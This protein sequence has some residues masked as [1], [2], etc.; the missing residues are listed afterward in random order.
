DPMVIAR[1]ALLIVVVNGCERRLFAA[2]AAAA[3]FAFS[4]TV[5]S[6][7]LGALTVKI[8]REERGGRMLV[9]IQIT[10]A[11]RHL[12]LLDIE[13]KFPEE[14]VDFVGLRAE[15]L[16]DLLR[17]RTKSCV[18]RSVAERDVDLH[19]S[20]MGRIEA[21]R[22]RLSVFRSIRLAEHRFDLLH[23]TLVERA[24]L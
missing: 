10:A 24:R 2:S 3:V 14:G 22:D 21:K 19:R 8:V 15:Q 4:R 18:K 17:F 13:T 16:R 6:P 12:H 23:E 1:S 11:D 9:R 7:A 5:S 20:E